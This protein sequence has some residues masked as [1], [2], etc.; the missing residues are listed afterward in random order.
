MRSGTGRSATAQFII[1]LLNIAGLVRNDK[2]RVPYDNTPA[3]YDDVTNM[4][5][6]LR[7]DGSIPFE[8]IADETRPVVVVGH[9]PLCRRLRPAGM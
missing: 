5:T 6:R 1:G 2:T 7:L 9:P 3:A 4:L 8:A